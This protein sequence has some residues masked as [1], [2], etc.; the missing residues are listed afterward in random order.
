MEEVA[1]LKKKD[2]IHMVQIQNILFTFY[3]LLICKRSQQPI[4]HT[5]RISLR[6]TVLLKYLYK[7]WGRILSLQNNEKSS[8]THIC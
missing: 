2:K 1:I 4:L 3:M 5:S 8:Y 6:Y 7:R